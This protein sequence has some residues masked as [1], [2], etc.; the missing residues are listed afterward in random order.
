MIRL[1]TSKKSEIQALRRRSGHRV[2]IFAG[3]LFACLVTDGHANMQ[4]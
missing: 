1:I 2:M 3:A 4:K